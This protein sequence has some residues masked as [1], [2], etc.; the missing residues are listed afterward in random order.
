MNNKLSKLNID[1]IFLCL[2]LF[3]I[4]SSLFYFIYQLNTYSLVISLL[5][6]YLPIKYLKYK[7]TINIELKKEEKIKIDKKTIILISLFIISLTSSF[8]ILFSSQTTESIIS[9]WQ[10][11]P[12]YFFIFFAFSVFTLLLYFQKKAINKK[13]GFLGIFLLYLLAFS[14]AI[15]IYKIGYGFD[16]FIHEATI[17]HIKNNGFILPKTPYYIGQYSLIIFLNKFFA[18]PIEFTNKI[19]VPVLSALFIPYFSYKFYKKIKVD[20]PVIL[21]AI[22]L[23]LILNFS[24]FIVST[25]QN[26]SY[27]FLLAT[28]IYGLNKQTLPYGVFSAL[29]TFFIHP[30]TGLPA[31]LFSLFL[32]AKQF[33]KKEKVKKISLNVLLSLTIFIIP[34]SLLVGAG[35]SYNLSFNTA[36]PSFFWSNTESLNLNFLYF[37]GHNA[38]YWLFF[39]IIFA[40]LKLRRNK[41]FYRTKDSLKIALALFLSFLISSFL[42]F[43]KLLN[44]EQGDYAKRILIIAILF[45]LPLF[46]LLFLEISL[47]INLNKNKLIF[48]IFFSLI[49][50]ASLYLSYPRQDNY[51]NSR[52]HSISQ[53]DLETVDIIE[54]WSDQKYIVLANQQSGVAA[55]KKTGF[56]GNYLNSNLGLLYFYSVPTGDPLYSFYLD[57]VYE[58]ANKET[59]IEAMNLAQ[60]N[61]A[62][63]IV[64][65]YWWASE[66]IIKEAELEANDY[67]RLKKEGLTIFKYTRN[68]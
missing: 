61:E 37:F 31:I 29:A 62:Y 14:V 17:K 44:Y 12:N 15:I 2:C 63:F 35:A 43:S 24:S 53:A 60:V 10:V 32:I 51:H 55:I 33:I 50:T 36:W 18:L 34:L 26:L 40:F 1:L 39:L 23:I 9:P 58:E 6:S 57:M 25:P 59:I 64:H 66:R 30:L 41:Y 7:K 48:L 65:D 27:L 21:L 28:I 13:L 47:K 46:Y 38:Y 20:K 22:V 19:L 16:P 68:N 42:N 11:V 67:T 49:I 8:I 54:K 52:G 3:I 45:T 5:L 56:T 4:F